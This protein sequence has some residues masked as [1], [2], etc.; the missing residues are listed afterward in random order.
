MIK[1][2]MVAMLSGVFSAFSQVLLKKSSNIEHRT[3]L[4]EYLNLYVILGYMLVLVC[5]MLMIFAYRGL[6]FKYGAVI[7]AL[8][9]L[10]VM[11]LGK[12]FFKEEITRKKVLGNMF[13]VCGVIVF[14]L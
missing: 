8:V 2:A 14:S 12:V 13:I 3:R 9:Y 4:K 1:Y 6:P 11:I 10:Y 5:M 7:E